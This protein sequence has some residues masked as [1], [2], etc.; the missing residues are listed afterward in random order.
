MNYAVILASGKGTR[1][2]DNI[3]IPKQFR[4]INNKPVIIYT[5]ENVLKINRFNHIYI[6]V[7]SNYLTYMKELLTK[8][9]KKD[10]EKISVIEGGKERINSIE[11]SIKAITDNNKIGEDDIVVI[12]DAVRPFVTAQI[13][14]DSI[15]NARSHGAV[16]TAAPVADT[17]LMSN[18]GN[19]VDQILK[20]EFYYKGQA[21]DSFNIKLFVKLLNQLSDE[22]RKMVTGTSQIC[23]MNNHPIYMIPGDDMNFKITTLSDLKIAENI[24]K[25]GEFND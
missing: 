15:D 17:L 18:D 21:P 3:D 22:D 11:N 8:Y 20:R 2:K 23:T 25:R 10:L 6:A 13:L 5:I 12:H 1:V 16:V 19:K 24:A 7:S 4:I 14:N 9:F